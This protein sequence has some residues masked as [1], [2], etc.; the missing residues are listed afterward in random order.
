MSKQLK[1]AIETSFIL[2]TID[3]RHVKQ[4]AG[5]VLYFE[6][7]LFVNSYNLK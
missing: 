7:I 6:N 2:V 5:F 4:N 1:I 3:Y